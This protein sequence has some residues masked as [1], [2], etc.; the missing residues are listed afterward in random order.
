MEGSQSSR[1][2]ISYFYLVLICGIARD[3]REH[4]ITSL[5]HRVWL[6]DCSS[7]GKHHHHHH[8]R[9]SQEKPMAFDQLQVGCHQSIQEVA[10][11]SI[12]DAVS[13]SCISEEVKVTSDLE[14]FS[15]DLVHESSITHRWSIRSWITSKLIIPPIIGSHKR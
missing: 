4:C 12:L 8:L 13:T 5:E 14:M 10:S 9:P 3:L 15:Q 2:G 11:S 6:Q 1:W 7:L